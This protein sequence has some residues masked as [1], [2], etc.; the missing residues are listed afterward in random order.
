MISKSLWTK[1][2]K[3]LDKKKQN[4]LKLTMPELVLPLK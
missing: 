3:S 2:Q 4:E 1:N